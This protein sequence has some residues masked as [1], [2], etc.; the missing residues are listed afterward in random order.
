DIFYQIS[1]LL[2][3]KDEED[4]AFSTQQQTRLLEM[5]TLIDEASTVM[6]ENQIEHFDDVTIDKAAEIEDRINAKRDEIR[7]EYYANV[8]ENRSA[9]LEGD[10]LYNN[11]Y[12]ALERIGDHIINVTEGVLGKV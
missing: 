10:L 2:E 9:D 6:Q 12:H 1:K 3:K 7:R 11:I 8:Q 4:V 5:L